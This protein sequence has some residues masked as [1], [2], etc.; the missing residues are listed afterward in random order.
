MTYV[1]EIAHELPGRIRIR[2]PAARG[3]AAAFARL[4]EDVA[5]AP[6]VVE[7]Q[8]SARTGSL[9]V[10]GGR[11][12]GRVRAA[13]ERAGLF[14]FETPPPRRARR[15]LEISPDTVLAVALSGLGLAQLVN[16]RATG[17]ASE[18][19]WNAFR[20]QTHLGNRAAAIGFTVLGLAQLARGRYLNSASSLLFYALTARQL[21]R[22]RGA[23]RGAARRR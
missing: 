3:D 18:N 7:V 12:N 4:V 19:F 17:P 8:G 11:G 10:Y 15:P 1:G 9:T 16:G 5:S 2:V 14:E 22:E 23:L 20:S 13:L 21:T 6:D